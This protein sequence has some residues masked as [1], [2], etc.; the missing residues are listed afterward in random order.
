M[1]FDVT[2]THYNENIRTTI[3]NQ[4]KSRT[5]TKLSKN[6][7]IT[8]IIQNTTKLN[9]TGWQARYNRS[10][11]KLFLARFENLM[12][13]MVFLYLAYLSENDKFGN[14]RSEN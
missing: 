3:T 8:W 2:K 12:L 6:S 13:S 10:C 9:T 11:R 14:N 7:K 1:D 5:T 4:K